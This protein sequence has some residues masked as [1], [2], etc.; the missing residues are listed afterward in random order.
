MGTSPLTVAPLPRAKSVGAHPLPKE[1]TLN[2]PKGGTSHSKGRCCGLQGSTP[3]LEE[4]TSPKRAVQP[5]PKGGALHPSPGP[6]AAHPRERS[7]QKRSAPRPKEGPAPD[8]PK[9][10]QLPPRGRTPAT[11]AA[12]EREFRGGGHPTRRHTAPRHRFDRSKG[13]GISWIVQNRRGR[14]RPADA[15]PDG[16][17]FMATI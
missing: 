10:A 16:A 17:D 1:A 7:P 12:A 11:Y 15:Q 8:S 6:N 14:S 3:H 13:W 4:V 2:R 5:T 9:G